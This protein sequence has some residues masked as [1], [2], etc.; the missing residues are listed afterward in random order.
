VPAQDSQ[1]ERMAPTTNPEMS[2]S[3]VQA[4]D[5]AADSSDTVVNRTQEQFLPSDPFP[6]A[7]QE[8]SVQ[9]MPDKLSK[10]KG[11]AP[12]AEYR[13]RFN[14]YD[15]PD[16]LAAENIIAQFQDE[17]EH[18]TVSCDGPLCKQVSP[19]IKGQR[20]KCTICD[21]VDFCLDCVASFHNDH[22]A[23]HAMVKC[24][25]PTRFQMIREIDDNAKGALL[26]SCGDPSATIED[27][28]HVIY[29]ETM[30][31]G[32]IRS[33]SFD[34]P[35]PEQTGSTLPADDSVTAMFVILRDKSHGS[36][37]RNNRIFEEG[38]SSNSV[39]YYK[40]DGAGNVRVYFQ[41]IGS[42]SSALPEERVVM[43]HM[44]AE[45]LTQVHLGQIRQFQYPRDDHFSQWAWKG[46]LVTRLI[47]LKPGSFDDKIEINIRAVDLSQA[48]KYEALS[49]TWKETTYERAHH[50]SWTKEVD[51]AF[52][53]ITKISHAVYCRDKSGRESYLVVSAGLRDALRRLRD[54]YE[55]KTYWID[56]LS[57]DQSN[58]SERAFQVSGMRH[59]YNGAQRVT[60]WTGDEDEDTKAAFD[61]LQN[62][63]QA[64][65]VLGYLP[66]PEELV[67]DANLDLPPF[68]S[69]TW[70]AVMKFFLRPVFERCWVIQEIVVSQKVIVRCGEQNITW[71]DL[72]RAALILVQGPW[73]QVLPRDLDHHSPFHT[74][75]GS[76]A[77]KDTALQKRENI[78]LGNVVMIKGFREDFQTLKEISL[79]SLL[80]STGIFEASDPR[81]K[82][83]SILGIR[84]AMIDPNISKEILPDYQKSV[85]EVFTEATRAVILGR[86]SL[87]ICGIND[88]LSSKTIKGLP[89]WVP[90]YSSSSNSCATSF[91]RPDPKNPY[92]ASGDSELVAIWPLEDHKDFLATSSYQAETVLTV[93]QNALLDKSLVGALVGEWTTLASNGPDYVTGEFAPDAFWRTCVGDNTL[94]WRRTPAPLSYHH[95]LSVFFAQYFIQHVVSEYRL[96]DRQVGESF[97]SLG[98]AGVSNAIIGTFLNDADAAAPNW[99]TEC[100]TNTDPDAIPAFFSTCQNRKFFVTKNRYFGIGP[101]DM[102]A[103]DEIHILSGACVPFVLRRTDASSD[104]GISAL[105]EDDPDFPLYT[106]IG[107]T[108]VH[109]LMKG[110]ALSRD[111]FEWDGIYIQ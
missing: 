85:A 36:V 37:S 103:G 46:Q 98:L 45:L 7:D 80:Y 57:I 79:E 33:R 74:N 108:Y 94:R 82:V 41:P 68:N 69:P 59:I 1:T 95:T 38:D 106:M 83:Y 16:Q 100:S 15:I 76:T 53:K 27:L 20:Y 4:V 51:E 50:S 110:E 111:G 39:A 32:L 105:A 44:D 47:D 6:L 70:K 19:R 40:I 91:S 34:D 86:S 29:A 87:N 93:A 71:E 65:R 55:T 24:L 8:D 12:A 63:S 3:N 72:S 99:L 77:S 88:S 25:L 61:I 31:Q 42:S 54:K 96:E 21:N 22:D 17:V 49:Y 62:I 73:L 56:Q 101:V 14:I 18:D 64:S 28:S 66:G 35:V 92:H 75:F 10:G 97:D 26:R 30:E 107:E 2:V 52:S 89:S 67:E 23:R 60:L 9:E 13:I 48:L 104:E 84:S 43:H 109:G 81:D 78:P 102:Q 11:K 90:D 58:L 5:S